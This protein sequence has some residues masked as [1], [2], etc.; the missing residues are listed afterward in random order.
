MKYQLTLRQHNQVFF[1]ESLYL[2]AWGVCQN[3]LEVNVIVNS[4]HRPQTIAYVRI[5]QQSWQH[6]QIEGK[7]GLL[8]M[9]GNL[10]GAF[11][12]VVYGF[13]QP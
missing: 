5:T 11:S 10:N 2:L 3:Q 8:S 4:Q 6:G 1:K 12:E 7:L 13:T 9:N